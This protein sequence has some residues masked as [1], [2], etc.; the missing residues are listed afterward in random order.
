MLCRLAAMNL[1]Y[2]L[3]AEWG[4]AEDTAEGTSMVFTQQQSGGLMPG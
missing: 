4:W 1:K 2:E 3:S